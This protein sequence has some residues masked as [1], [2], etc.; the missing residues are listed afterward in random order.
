MFVLQLIFLIDEQR[1]KKSPTSIDYKIR[2]NCSSSSPDSPGPMRHHLPF[3]TRPVFD[4]TLPIVLSSL[5]LRLV[6][7]IEES[8][9]GY[10]V[11]LNLVQSWSCPADLQ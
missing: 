10:L 7:S 11:H 5:V 8:T 9:V 2:L 4:S 1:L 6:S 3:D